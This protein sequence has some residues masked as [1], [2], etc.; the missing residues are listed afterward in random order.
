MSRVRIG[1]CSGP[2]DAALVKAALEAHDIHVL[3]NAEQHASMLGGLGGAF[4]PLHIFVDSSQ[5]EQAAALLADLRSRDQPPDE[6]LGD[7]EHADDDESEAEA[8]LHARNNR[9]RRI[10]TV[11]VVMLAMGVGLPF[12]ADSPALVITL[13]VAGLA[14]I[15]STMVSTRQATN[16]PRARIRR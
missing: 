14:A 9:K 3:I 13:I 15:A 7:V 10:G 8:V 16:L 1:T 12:V 6:L 5:A 2:A 4:V 11:L